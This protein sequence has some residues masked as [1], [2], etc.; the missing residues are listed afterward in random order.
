METLGQLPLRT[1]GVTGG[2]HMVFGELAESG[3]GILK[4]DVFRCRQCRRVEF[5]DLDLSIPAPGSRGS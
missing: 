5:Y 1:G 2:W 3:E 4:L